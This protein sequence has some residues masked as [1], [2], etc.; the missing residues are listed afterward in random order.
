[1]LSNYQLANIAED[2]K[3]NLP[4]HQ[5]L[6]KDELKSAKI[7]NFIINLQS[8]YQG[9]GSHWCAL[10]VEKNEAFWCDSFASPPPLEIIQACKKNKSIK[11]LYFNNWIIQHIDSQLCGFYCLGLLLYI[12][13]NREKYPSLKEC[14]NSWINLFVDE[15]TQNGSIL[16]YFLKSKRFHHHDLLNGSD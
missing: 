5:I 15:T 11:H 3:L 16:K 8:T 7:A 14:S 1:M 13:M 2:L 4:I 12:K 9:N 6:M 10:I